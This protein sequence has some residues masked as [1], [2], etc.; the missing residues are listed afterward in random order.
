VFAEPL[1]INEKM[2]TICRAFAY[3]KE[4]EYTYRQT[5]EMDL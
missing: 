4:E 1:P 5:D 3:Q 2:D